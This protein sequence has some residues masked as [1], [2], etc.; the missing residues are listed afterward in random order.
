M[1]EK[2]IGVGYQAWDPD[3]Y[4]S[5]LIHDCLGGKDSV[6]NSALFGNYAQNANGT[7]VLDVLHLNDSQPLGEYDALTVIGGTFKSIIP[8]ITNILTN[9]IDV[10]VFG[11]L[12]VKFADTAAALA[13]PGQAWYPIITLTGASAGVF[14]DV[15][16]NLGDNVSIKICFTATQ[17]VLVINHNTATNSAQFVALPDNCDFTNAGPGAETPVNRK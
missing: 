14:D 15:T 5:S 10:Y 1:T 17:G 6:G 9:I 2:F 16:H 12:Q 7:S 11:T 8:F 3:R 13:L 4:L